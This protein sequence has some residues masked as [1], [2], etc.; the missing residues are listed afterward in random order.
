MEGVEVRR[1]GNRVVIL[2]HR[3]EGCLTDTGVKLTVR[4]CIDAAEARAVAPCHDGLLE[5]SQITTSIDGHAKG[6]VGV[7]TLTAELQG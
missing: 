6:M 5:S 7:A 4:S 1:G 3:D 2:H